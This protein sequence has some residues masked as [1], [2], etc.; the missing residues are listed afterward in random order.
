MKWEKVKRFVA[1]NVYDMIIQGRDWKNTCPII[2]IDLIKS[3]IDLNKVKGETSLHGRIFKLY[4]DYA[5]KI[6]MNWD[7]RRAESLRKLFEFPKSLQKGKLVAEYDEDGDWCV[8]V[9][10]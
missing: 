4:A 9:S 10:K 5:E 2:L 3:E 8:F 6:I 1:T 7:I